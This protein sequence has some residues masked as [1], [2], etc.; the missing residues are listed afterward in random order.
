[1]HAVDVITVGIIVRLE[2]GRPLLTVFQ[3]MPSGSLLDDISQ[4]ALG[5]LTAI[6]V[7]AHLWTLPVVVLLAFQM[8]AAVR[9]NIAAQQH[10]HRMRTESERT[11]DA[12]REFLLT[13][14]HEL[15]TPITSVKM[16]AQLLDRALIQRNPAFQVD[17]ERLIRWRDQLLLGIERLESLVSDLLD[18]ARIQQGR[19]E[20]HPEYCDL[21]ALAREVVERFEFSAERTRL[22]ELVLD[23]PEPVEGYWDPSAIDQVLTNFISNALKYSPDGGIVT[24][25]SKN[26]GDSGWCRC[27]TRASAFRTTRRLKYSNRSREWKTLS[28]ESAGPGWVSTSRNGSSSNM[29]APSS[30][31]ASP[32]SGRR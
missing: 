22:H 20:I 32:A 15:K 23:A 25:R 5:L 26:V 3:E 28:M 18:A 7:D 6:S 19:L 21:A 9:R 8:Y 27:L 31:I 4:F 16:A 17:E 14:S 1:M 12:R 2:T 10:E 29:V 24:V 11:A 30:S 13:A